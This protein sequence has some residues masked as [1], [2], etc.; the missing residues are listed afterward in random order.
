MYY[1]LCIAPSATPY[2]TGHNH[3]K[4]LA[5]ALD[6]PCIAAVETTGSAQFQLQET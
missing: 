6:I 3:I 5:H 2:I 1:L 4:K